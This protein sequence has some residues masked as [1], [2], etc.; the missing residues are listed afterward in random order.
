MLGSRERG[1]HR[2]AGGE[3]RVLSDYGRDR[4]LTYAESFL[5]LAKSLGEEPG[6]S[7]QG[8]GEPVQGEAWGRQ[9]GERQ[10]LE[11]SVQGEAWGGR[12][13]ERQG[14]GEPVQGQDWESLQEEREALWEASRLRENRLVLC[15]HLEEMSRIMHRAAWEAYRLRPLP[16]K[17]H[18]QIV[19]ALRSEGLYVGELFYIDGGEEPAR[20]ERVGIGL[21]TDRQGG[22]PLRE[23]GDMLSALTGRELVPSAAC[24][25]KVEQETREYLFYRAP[26]FTVFPGFARAV[27]EGERVSGDNYSLVES[28]QG[29]L[30][31]L[32]SDGMGSG[33]KASQDSGKVLDLMEKLLEAGYDAAAAA[34]LVN[35]AL[36]AMGEQ[37]NMSTLDVCSLDLYSGMCRFCKAGAAA[38]FLKSGSYVEQIAAPHLPLGIL[39]PLRME[40]VTRELIDGDYLIL[41]SDGVLDA[42]GEG[43]YEEM[44]RR[45]VG[46]LRESNPGEMAAKVLQL[47]LGAGRGRVADDMTVM[48]LGVFSRER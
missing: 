30:T 21:C 46:D 3:S 23:V 36:M 18:R 25:P 7:G 17:L 31:A 38:S 34:E 20:G 13:G 6:G 19:R 41:V 15:H 43:G 9:Q 40:P 39:L 44:M 1:A 4:L 12:Q 32:L 42:L 29:I 2:G 5:E 11:E 24:P 27:K 47:A 35:S 28:D 37:H 26:R 8:L 22:V 16:E 48:V 14:Q 45:F 10:G 33:E